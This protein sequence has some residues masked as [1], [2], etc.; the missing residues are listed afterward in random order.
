MSARALV[1]ATAVLAAVSSGAVGAAADEVT[2]D[3]T[4]GYNTATNS[5]D[6]VASVGT[7]TLSLNGDG[8]ITATLATTL[9]SVEGVGIDSSIIPAQSGY[10]AEFSPTPWAT[11]LGNYNTGLA[12]VGGSS[13][14]SFQWIVG[15]PNQFT[16]VNQLI[17]GTGTYGDY[18]FW[19]SVNPQSGNIT[20]WGGD[21]EAVPEPTSLTLLAT[22]LVGLGA[23]RRRRKAL[24]V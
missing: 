24:A 8:T 15:S 19:I 11:D 12:Y 17:D 23:R 2:G 13:T 18:D 7:L 3:F 10:P 9:T 1:R 22:A 4:Y 16:S 14:G 21:I 5:V 20:E 6:T